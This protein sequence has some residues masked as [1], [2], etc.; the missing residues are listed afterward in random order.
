MPQYEVTWTIDVDA[1]DPIDAARR[2]LAAHPRRNTESWATVVTATDD[3]HEHLV[4][5]DP[6]GVGIDHATPACTTRPRSRGAT[7]LLADHA[8]QAPA[9]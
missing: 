7:G 9:T 8:P 4:D 1:D 2:A 6:E 5:L 3:R